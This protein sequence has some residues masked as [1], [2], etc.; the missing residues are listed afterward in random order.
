[1][2]Q[3]IENPDWDYEL[4]PESLY[5][6][7]ACAGV[8]L[9]IEMTGAQIKECVHP[10]RCDEDVDRIMALPEIK[11]QL[12]KISCAEIREWWDNFFCDDT[13]EEHATATLED[14]YRWMVFDACANAIDGYCELID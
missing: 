4:N 11:A 9:S 8:V 12:E 14:M 5:L 6:V 10:G 13:P 3:L 7:E 2:G 1:M